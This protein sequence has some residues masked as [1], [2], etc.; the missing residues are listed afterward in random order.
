MLSVDILIIFL[1]TLLELFD[2]ICIDCMAPPMALMQSLSLSQVTN[3]RASNDYANG[4]NYNV[5]TGALL[6]SALGLKPSKDNFWTSY[7]EPYPS[8]FRPHGNDQNSTDVHAISALMSCGPVGPS[9]RAGWSN[10]TLIMRTCRADGRLLQPRRPITA[11]ND[12][13]ISK[14]FS[15]QNINVWSTEFGPYDSRGNVEIIGRV[16]YATNMGTSYDLKYDSFSP[17]LDS[18]FDYVVRSWYNYTNCK[19]GS[20]A[21]QNGCIQ[22][23]KANSKILYTLQPQKTI[24][25][26]TDSFELIHVLQD[27]SMSSLVFL[28]ELDKYVSVSQHRF[29]N[30]MIEGMTLSVEVKGQANETVNLSV[31]KPNA[32]ETDFNV[33][34]YP[35]II[36]SSEKM[37]FNLNL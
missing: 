22:F 33:Y 17:A 21:M 29:G 10:A 19:N 1:F 30:L 16:I 7:L 28:G 15:G 6:W 13:F 32:Q 11:I 5:G 9:D 25:P 18:N 26:M 14:V 24:Y 36:G 20:L 3:G 12:Q 4:D 2:F 37:T 34:T 35:V 23:V 31:L 8:E 27:V